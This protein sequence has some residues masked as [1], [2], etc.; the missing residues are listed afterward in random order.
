MPKFKKAPVV[1]DAIQWHGTNG[2]ELLDWI[3]AFGENTSGTEIGVDFATS[4]VTIKTLEGEMRGT[5]G[6][7]VIRG[8][9]GEY[10]P[11]KPDIFEKTYAPDLGGTATPSSEGTLNTPR[12]VFEA[13]CTPACVQMAKKMYMAYCENS[14]NKNFRGEECPT[15]EDLT[16]EVRSHWCAAC[17][18]ALPHLNVP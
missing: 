10:Y 14:G 9:K 5:P 3:A 15:W 1:I 17:V 18:A 7:W 11:C 4:E 2:N 6:D 13:R 12:G 8:V 16:T